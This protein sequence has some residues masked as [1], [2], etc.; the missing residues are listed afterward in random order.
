MYNSLYFLVN[1]IKLNLS[2]IVSF[3]VPGLNHIFFVKLYDKSVFSI[4]VKIIVHMNV[5]LILD[6]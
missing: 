2:V 6:V 5:F 4:S 3:W 1:W